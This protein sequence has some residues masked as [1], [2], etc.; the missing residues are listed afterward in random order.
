MA[1]KL[2][3]RQAQFV[4]EYLID[5]NATQAA[6]RSGYSPKTAYSIGFENL[7]KPDIQEAIQK[8]REE[9][10]KALHITQERILQEEARLAFL[11]VGS[12]FDE[13]DNL[14]PVH[15][16]PEDARRAIAGIEIT[17]RVVLGEQSK[18]E[19]V[20]DVK[21]KY[22]VFDKGRAL[23]RI[24]KHLGLYAP[25]KH[26]HTGKDGGPIAMTDFPAEPKTI[27]EWEAMRNE[28]EEKR[29]AKNE[30]ANP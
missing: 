19:R 18:K 29:K 26:E 27:A 30:K 23:E 25:K 7:K 22:R 28:A 6:L 16:I 20:K 12:L 4:E 24:S 9:L 11:D 17:D 14:L 8:R 13:N 15:E 21:R 5:L 1:K 2:N 3:H 10:Q